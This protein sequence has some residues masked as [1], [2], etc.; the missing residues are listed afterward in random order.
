[1][2]HLL[3]LIGQHN[4]IDRNTCRFLLC[5]ALPVSQ[6]STIENVPMAVTL[7]CTNQA[8][9][10]AWAKVTPREPVDTNSRASLICVLS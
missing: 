2:A 1:M 7:L 8:L 10:G 4:H 9:Q 6:R 3:T 5:V